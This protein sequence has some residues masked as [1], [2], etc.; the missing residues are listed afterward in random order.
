MC[1][2]FPETYPLNRLSLFLHAL[3][4]LF[5]L[6]T[7]VAFAQSESDFVKAFAGRWQ[8]LDPAFAD[9]G[10]CRLDLSAEKKGNSYAVATEHCAAD[11]ADISLWAIMD[12][13]LALLGPEMK[14]G[15]RLGGNQNRMTGETARGT[16][17]VFERLPAT[18]SAAALPV[19]PTPSGCVY[20]GYT[21]TCVDANDMAAP[22]KSA[23]DA[24]AKASTLVR[25]NARA[26]ARPDAPI[27]AT[28]PANTCVAVEQCSTA[29]DGLWCK[30]KIANFVGWIPQKSVRSNKWNVLTFKNSC[31]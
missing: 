5:T 25:L 26:E 16:A 27:V 19:K 24:V 2:P 10:A 7:Q 20:Y 1:D 23:S 21:A 22:K 15:A 13:Q 9:K 4:V 18:S 29:S 8:T 28:I 12:N 17:L 31:D 30:A 11:L 6:N 14:V 3:V